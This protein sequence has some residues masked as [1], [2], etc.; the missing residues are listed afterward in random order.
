MDNQCPPPNALTKLLK[1]DHEVGVFENFKSE[2]DKQLHPG[3]TQKTLYDDQRAVFTPLPSKSVQSAW[4]FGTRKAADQDTRTL[5]TLLSE[6]LL[7]NDLAGDLKYDPQACGWEDV[8]NCTAKAKT[9]YDDKGKSNKVRAWS[10]DAD[11]TADILKSLTG[12][13]PDEKGL[14]VLRQGLII[15]FQVSP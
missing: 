5:S 4:K 9:I 15:I 14:S 7:H 2:H 1:D 6:S 13:I 8:I 12:M 3:F 11:A 10:R